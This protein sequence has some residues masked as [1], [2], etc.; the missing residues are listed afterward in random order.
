MLRKL[1]PAV[2]AI[3]VLLGTT[4]SLPSFGQTLRIAMTASDIPTTTGLPNNGGEGFRFLGFPAFDGLIDWDFTRPD[5]IAGLTPGLAASWKIDEGDHTRW[6]FSLRDGVTFHDGSVLTADAVIWNLDRFY[7]E[8]S[9]QFDA[10]ASAIV[11]SFVNMLDRY[12]KIDDHTIAIYT[13][14]PFSFFPYMVPTMLMVS[15]TAWEKAGRSWTEFGKA[16]SGTGPFRITKVVP[17]QS[18]EMSRNESYWDKTRIPKLSK[19]IVIPMPE[20]TTRLASLRSGQVDWIE[21]PPPDAIPSLKAA[22]FQIS[23]WPYPHVWPYILNVTEGSS[24]SRPTGAQGAE[25]RDRSRRARQV[26]ERHGQAGLWGLPS[27]EPLFRQPG[28]ALRPRPGKGQGSPSRGRVRP[29]PPARG[30]SYDLDVRLGADGA[31]ADERDPAAAGAGSRLQARF[32]RR[33][34]GNDARRQANCTVGAGRARG[35]CPEQQ[36]R[37]Q[38]PGIDV[39]LFQQNKLLAERH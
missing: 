11:R 4:T 1:L 36:S 25:L 28:A 38:R 5:Q 14:S 37:L 6:V 3:A 7:N 29:G 34:L 2:I 12:Q 24:V 8:K 19:L 32:R 10:P 30:E 21:V 18:V 15:P 35:R 20:A 13:K 23:L 16:P 9:P 33:R 17:G 26:L 31:I 22:G 27:G 39:P